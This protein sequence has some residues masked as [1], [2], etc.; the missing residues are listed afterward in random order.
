MTKLNFFFPQNKDLKENINDLLMKLKDSELSHEKVRL[1]LERK[2]QELEFEI[3]QLKG[4][5][6]SL[7]DEN[8]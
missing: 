2:I 7:E 6:K 3:K 4:S 1:G 8:K 5:K